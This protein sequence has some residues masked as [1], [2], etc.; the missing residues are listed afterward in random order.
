MAATT[1]TRTVIM[2]TIIKSKKS[3]RKKLVGDP[4]TRIE[5]TRKCLG[6]NEL[7]RKNTG[8]SPCG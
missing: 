1:T 8:H 4:H 5:K 6:V 3:V 7:A 2:T